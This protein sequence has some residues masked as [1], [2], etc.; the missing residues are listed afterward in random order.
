MTHRRGW[1]QAPWEKWRLQPDAARETGS[2][3]M[4]AK[5]YYKLKRTKASWVCKLALIKT[6]LKTEVGVFLSLFTRDTTV[7]PL[8][9][10]LLNRNVPHASEGIAGV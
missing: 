4:K 1:S 5:C 2:P 10:A 8:E 6:V 3:L 7:F 9:P